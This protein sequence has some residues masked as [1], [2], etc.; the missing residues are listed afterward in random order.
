MRLLFMSSLALTLHETRMGVDLAD[1]LA[2]AGVTSHFVIDAYNEDQLRHTAHTYTTVTSA[3]GSRVRD[4]VADV[5]REFRPDALVLCDYTAHWMTH[6]ISYDTDPWYVEDF[7]VPVIPIDLYDLTRTGREV[8]IL[9]R[10]MQVSDR[11]LDMPAHLWPVPGVR[12]HADPDGP[13][14]PY[15]A[16]PTVTPL[17]RDARREV[18]RSLGVADGDRLLAIPALPWQ[19]LM[20]TRAGPATR[21]LAGRVPELVAHYLSKLPKETR[22]LFVGPVFDGF[23]SLPA[24]RVVRRPTYTSREY[25]DLLG[26]SDGVMSLFLPSFA[27]ERAILADVPGLFTLNSFAIDAGATGTGAG[28][29]EEAFGGLSP[30]VRAWLASHP[31]PIPPFH[32]WPLRWTGVVGPLLEDNPFTDTALRTELFDEESVVAGVEAVL[33]DPVVRDT[34]AAGRAAFRD[35]LDRLPPTAEVFMTAAERAGARG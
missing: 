33:Y 9:G 17:S 1:Q 34:L 26:A 22:F 19:H 35:A 18:R 14:L 29:L 23:E 11:I 15:R 3:L 12:P 24:D 28:E 7:G 2:P 13:A 8:E 10:T 20:Q 6:V 31:G 32:M 25:T 27:L 16:D 30:E 5:V 4:D 21:A